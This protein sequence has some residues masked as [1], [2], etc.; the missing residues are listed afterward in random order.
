MA[1]VRLT[2]VHVDEMLS[3][4]VDGPPHV[5]LA[6]LVLVAPLLAARPRAG[7]GPLLGAAVVP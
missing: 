5:S 4:L 6:L 3:V 7:G 2:D 1:A